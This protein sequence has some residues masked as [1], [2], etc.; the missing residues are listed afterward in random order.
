MAK[1]K[2]GVCI[3]GCGMMGNIHAERWDNNP[4]ATIV[5]AADILSDRAQA[6]A[7][8]YNLAYADTDYRAAIQ[9]SGVDVV[10]VCVPTNLHA[11]ISRFALIQGKHVLCEKP[12]ALS[13]DDA[14]AMAASAH[15]AGRKL[16][17][18]LMRR[19]SPALTFLRDWLAS[20]ELGRPVLYHASD[21]R[22]IRPKLA[23]HDLAQNGGPAIDM[24]VHLYDTWAC[25][26]Q[27]SVVEVIGRGLTIA[28]DR[29]ELVSIPNLAPDTATLL[30]RFASGDIGT[31]IV[32]WGLPPKVIPPPMPDFIYGPRGVAEVTFAMKRQTV[33]WMKEGGEWKTLIDCDQDMYQL[34]IDAMA[35][36]VLDDAPFPAS[37]EAGEAALLAALAGLEGIFENR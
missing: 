32:S 31:F 16:G 2:L 6:F 5:A 18:G 24:A 11:D 12:I 14:H 21:I 28:S 3:I 23:M 20:G 13:K 17:I 37:A 29:S 36:W 30:A 35:R 8:R 27:S 7:Q 25:A 22:E 26:F 4:S 10:S 33:R 9:R 19:H 34:E 1:E 15:I